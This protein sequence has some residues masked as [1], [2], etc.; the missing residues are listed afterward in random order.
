MATTGQEKKDVVQRVVDAADDRDKET[1]IDLHADDA[2]LHDAGE[3]I[4]GAERVA[5]HLWGFF[6]AFT[7]MSPTLDTLIAEGDLVAVRMT[8][9]GTH[10]RD[11]EGIEPTGT[12]VDVEEMT[13]ARVKDGEVVEVWTLADRLGMLEATR[14]RRMI[15]RVNTV[16]PVL[17]YQRRT[18]A[19]EHRGW[20]ISIP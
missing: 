11:F 9:S 13:L 7:D 1:F 4:Q 2:V 19:S 16:T 17:V 20:A 12:E 3:T 15:R 18:T 14:C 6:G 5:D 8:G 10:E